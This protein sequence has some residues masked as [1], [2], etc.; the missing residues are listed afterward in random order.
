[1]H[2]FAVKRNAD[3][4]HPP[5]PSGNCRAPS[6]DVIRLARLVAENF[7]SLG[8]TLNLYCDQVTAQADALPRWSLGSVTDEASV[9]P[10]FESRSRSQKFQGVASGG[11][12]PCFQYEPYTVFTRIAGFVTIHP[13]E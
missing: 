1:V 13:T 8:A 9:G 7:A 3:R 11:V 2:G 12:T 5:Q 10:W 4:N 6:S